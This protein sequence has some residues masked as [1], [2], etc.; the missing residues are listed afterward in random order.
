VAPAPAPEPRN[1]ETAEP[2][3][4]SDELVPQEP[5]RPQRLEP[6]PHDPVETDLPPTGF[7]AL[8]PEITAQLLGSFLPLMVWLPSM[9]LGVAAFVMWALVLPLARFDPTVQSTTETQPRAWPMFCCYGCAVGIG[10]WLLAF[11]AAAL[12]GLLSSFVGPLAAI[13]A[14]VLNQPSEWLRTQASAAAAAAVGLVATVASLAMVA[15]AGAGFYF[16]SFFVYGAFSQ[17]AMDN[18]RSL[19]PVFIGT[20]TAFVGMAGAM[21][22]AGALAALLP[23]LATTLTYLGIRRGLQALASRNG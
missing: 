23:P 2:E 19:R 17:T 7:A 1:V 9:G 20:S 18:P 4:E 12:G 10:G 6:A 14:G 5:T 3:P 16:L 13:G 11:P 8:K 21:L 22:T 15:G